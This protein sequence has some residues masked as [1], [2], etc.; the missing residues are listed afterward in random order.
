MPRL[1]RDPDTYEHARRLADDGVGVPEIAR[2]LDV[3]AATV[4]NWL[5]RRPAY[6]DASKPSPA[7]VCHLCVSRAMTDEERRAYAY[8]LGI[9]LGDGSITG[10]RRGVYRVR[11]GRY[12]YPRYM[13]SNRSVDIARIFQE[14]CDAVGAPWP[15][16]KWTTSVSRRDA[17]ALLDGLIGPKA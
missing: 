11:G 2:L 13:F 17:V 9:Y 7:N 5:I 10:G 16:H 3:P 4:G 15:V 1:R 6:L 14:A 12:V 8:L